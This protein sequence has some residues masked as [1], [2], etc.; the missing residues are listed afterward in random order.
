MRTFYALKSDIFAYIQAYVGFTYVI[1]KNLLENFE[2]I[3]NIF[4]NLFGK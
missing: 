4:Y 2:K 3:K 1:V